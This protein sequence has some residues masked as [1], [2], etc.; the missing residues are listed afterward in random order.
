MVD[1][2]KKLEICE[3][4]NVLARHYDIS[5]VSDGPLLYVSLSFLFFLS[6]SHACISDQ[7]NV[8]EWILAR[9][10]RDVSKNTHIRCVD[11]DIPFSPSL[12]APCRC[13]AM[14]IFY[15]NRWY[16]I[17]LGCRQKFQFTVNFVTV[18]HSHVSRAAPRDERV[19]QEVEVPCHRME[20]MKILIVKW[21]R[22]TQ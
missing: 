3:Q 9:P 1:G 11:H 13:G 5:R 16:K 2:A 6:L 19:A 12:A 15:S 17:T 10:A 22:W 14:E 21:K 18:V 20:K 8:R 7:L 4:Q